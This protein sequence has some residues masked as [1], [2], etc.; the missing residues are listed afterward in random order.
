MLCTETRKS[1]QEVDMVAKVRK[2]GHSQEGTF[3]RQPQVLRDDP[4]SSS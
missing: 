1:M 3:T 4:I 2:E